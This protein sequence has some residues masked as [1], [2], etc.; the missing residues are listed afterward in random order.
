[1]RAVT[2]IFRTLLADTTVAVGSTMVQIRKAKSSSSSSSSSSAV[3]WLSWRTVIALVIA[4]QGLNLAYKLWG[5]ATTMAS[6]SLLSPSSSSS[7][8]SL[9]SS[10]SLSRKKSNVVRTSRKDAAASAG[11]AAATATAKTTTAVSK[12][13]STTN[14]HKNPLHHQQL[15]QHQERVDKEDIHNHLDSGDLHPD[16]HLH[17]RQTDDEV[18]SSP[19]AAGYVVDLI[20]GRRNPAFR[21]NPLPDAALLLTQRT[22]LITQ[23]LQDQYQRFLTRPIAPC[24]TYSEAS[25]SSKQQQ[26]QQRSGT[27]TL[28]SRPSTVSMALKEAAACQEPA[29]VLY[30]YN[31]A[32][33]SRF[34][35]GHEIAPHAVYQWVHKCPGHD[36]S[37]VHHDAI[38]TLFA[39]KDDSQGPPPTTTIAV[40]SA[41]SHSKATTSLQDIATRSVPCDYPCAWQDSLSIAP[42]SGSEGAAAVVPAPKN[43]ITRL[44]IYGTNWT[45]VHSTA[46]PYYHAGAKMERTNYR[47]NI[48]Y[49]TLSLTSSVPLSMF[50]RTLYDF[51]LY[52]PVSWATAAPKVTY[53][54][55][56]DCFAGR[57]HKWYAAVAA[58]LTV[59]AY[60]SCQ[61]NSNVGA[62][63]TLDT[64]EGRVNLMRK[65]R[66]TL[67]LEAGN[68][69]DYITSIVWEAL[70][71]GN[72]PA[73]NGA[74]N[75]EQR[76]PPNSAILASSFNSWDK[77][78]AHIAAVASNQTLWESYQAWRSDPAAVKAFLEQWDFVKTSPECRTCRWA[79]AKRYGL[80]WNHASQT[81][82]P[83]HLDR[84]LCRDD[85][86]HVTRPFR[87]TYVTHRSAAAAA[88]SLSRRRLAATSSTC[89]DTYWESSIDLPNF[90]I[91]RRVV[92]HDGVIDM[93]LTKLVASEKASSSK[94]EGIVLR[95][96]FATIRN[97]DGAY[98]S[99]P[100]S[101]VT[102]AKYGPTVSSAALQ[103]EA[104][105]VTVLADWVT[106]IHSPGEG[107]LEVT[108]L[109]PHDK[110]MDETA[111]S[112]W[113]PRRLRVIVENANPLHDKLTEFYPSTFGR[114]MMHDFIDP[115]E[116]YYD[117]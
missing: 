41:A 39:E 113:F 49:S 27:T 71:A 12:Q 2:S 46:D 34:H 51:S 53:L 47:R 61:H 77:F 116:F 31:A 101:L 15:A 40:L 108:I 24:R 62:R 114:H 42:S 97:T 6:S 20:A 69:K 107:I 68:E 111:L 102:E 58:V 28:S 78:A 17:E 81:V 104:I 23:Q 48:Y 37:Q 26:S 52:P 35:C 115:L 100:H 10:L 79:L 60:G 1:V 83:L 19:T 38:V 64:L 82:Q 98:F 94:Y 99:D 84:T 43:D 11:G 87:E 86:H 16:I 54:Q 88:A 7:S 66:I 90:Q 117:A 109:S 80:G 67:A 96:E 91:E 3:P 65:N 29:V 30:A 5:H 112:A 92:A 95:L 74:N 89:T 63:E 103:D 50:D 14:Q 57:R 44:H 106:R 21:H 110:D 8:S 32:P 72:V 9:Q 33:F 25:S 36:A 70:L 18:E 59:E 105:K 55:N 93:T 73:I 76:L 75:L 56:D 4:A 13:S 45:V 85:Q 22:A